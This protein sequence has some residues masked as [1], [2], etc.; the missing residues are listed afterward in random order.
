MAR[1]GEN[2]YL[3]KD[4]RYEGRY[5]IGRKPNG[6]TAFGYIY[7]K[8]YSDVKIRLSIAKGDYAK[9]GNTTMTVHSDGSV[10][11]WMRLWLEHYAKPGIKESTLGIYTQQVEKHIIPIIGNV[12]MREVTKDTLR[13]LY[14]TI[15]EKGGSIRTAQ[16]ICR[17]FRSSLLVAQ[18]ENF[19]CTVPALPFKNI[20]SQKK[21]PRYLSDS[22][23]ELLESTLE[24]DSAKD[25][26]VLLGIYTGMRIG[27]CCALKWGDI[28]FNEHEITVSHTF[29]RISSSNSNQKTSL[30]YTSPKSDNATRKI[31]MTKSLEETLLHLKGQTKAYDSCFVFGSYLK[32]IEPRTLQYHMK[33]LEQH[34]HLTGL[35]FHTLRHTF[36]TRCLEMQIDI[37][38][39]SELLG[40]SS[41]Q[42]TL[43]WYCHSSRDRK[44]VLI[45]RIDK[46]AA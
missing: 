25:C 9:K 40:H 20:T 27:E 23:Q 33:K 18:D 13:I 39:L 31:P 8:K 17:R 21:A 11:A 26:A 29:Q 45:Q 15:Q 32:P 24:K 7:G 6:Q 37:K 28:D 1:H 43:D 44:R 16:N 35:H 22:E 34:T 46:P 30:L 3:R 5:V 2:I 42:I 4:G 19:I 36:A 14:Q 41:A 10:S 38:T 12:K